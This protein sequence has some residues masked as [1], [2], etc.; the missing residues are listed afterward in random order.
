VRLRTVLAAAALMA[1]VGCGGDEPVPLEKVPAPVLQAAEK[2]LPGLKFQKA[3]KGQYKGEVAYEVQG[4]TKTGE[5]REVEV[6][7]SGKVFNIE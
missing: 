4:K 2:A 3:Y 5:V 1:V 7:G 6:T